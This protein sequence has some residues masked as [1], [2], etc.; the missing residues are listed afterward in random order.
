MSPQL[1][2]IHTYYSVLHGINMGWQP[3]QLI[4]VCVDHLE[5][6]HSRHL[7]RQYLHVEC[8]L[9]DSCVGICFRLNML[10]M[11]SMCQSGTTVDFETAIDVSERTTLLLMTATNSQLVRTV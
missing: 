11:S 5:P 4:M 2:H 6:Q 9:P 1:L 7:A 8:C 3:R 10:L